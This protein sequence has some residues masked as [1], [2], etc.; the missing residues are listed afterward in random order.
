MSRE[1]DEHRFNVAKHDYLKAF[2]DE[3][4]ARSKLNEYMLRK[5][6]EI[7]E[8]RELLRESN[9]AMHK[10]FEVKK[11]FDEVTEEVERNKKSHWN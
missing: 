2:I 9:S 10:L 3:M 7:E 5:D 8:A 6:W 1:S 11:D 4:L